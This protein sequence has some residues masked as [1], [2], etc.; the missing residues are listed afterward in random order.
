[1][2]F[3][4]KTIL[5]I[6]LIEGVLLIILIIAGMQ[7]LKSSNVEELHKRTYTTA[8]LFATTVKDAVLATDL[9]SLDNFV[10][11]VMTHPGIVYAR[12]SGRQGAVLAQI[13][14]AALLAR[15][16]KPDTHYD[17]V[18][19]GVFDVYADIVV[20]EDKY[21]R[22][23]IGFSTANID[24]LLSTA[25]NEFIA[26]A[27]TE[28]LL[29]ALFSFVLG[30]YLTKG[31]VSLTQTSQR[32]A[33]GELGG[34]I[35]VSGTDELAQ[36]MR[37]FNEMSHKLKVFYDERKHAED[38][39]HKLNADLERRVRLRTEEINKL[40][41]DLE[42]RVRLRTEE[43]AQANERIEH[44]AL[45]DPLTKLANRTL[46]QDRLHQA[47]L[48]GERE[49]RVFALVMIDLNRFK[50]INDTLGHHNGD[51][52]LRETASRLSEG[53]RQS[54]TIARLGGDEYALLL[55]TVKDSVSAIF[56]LD[57]IV[58]LFEKPMLLD[59]L[60]TYISPSL[61][62]ALYP[63]DG[64]DAETLMRR[65]DVAMYE[66]KHRK[67]GHA[68]YTADLEQDGMDR[69]GLQSEL[70]SGIANAELVLHYQPKIDI[71]SGRV[72]GVEALVRWHH[73]KR[74][75]LAPDDFI[76]L[77]EK[78]GLI[79]PLTTWVLKEALRQCKEWEIQGLDLV[80]SVNISISNLQDPVFPQILSHVLS[81]SGVS[82]A[83]LELEISENGIMVEPP[84]AIEA[85]LCLSQLGVRI[86][87][88]DFGT[89]YSSMAYLSKLSVARIKVDKSFVKDMVD[90]NNNAVI[91]R[92][93]I[94]LGHN[95]GLNVVAE[96]VENNATWDQL[97]LL[98]CDSAQGYC[99]S[100]PIP[101]EQIPQWVKSSSWGASI[102]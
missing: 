39:V 12:V 20:G 7:M 21:G 84:R 101:A 102:K 25:R 10:R 54:D 100:R 76:P 5:G 81:E 98:G 99:M 34:Q 96:G 38:E 47:I 70:L 50:E 40:N 78:T 45:H 18:G 86:I 71:T 9:A 8:Q 93:I 83:K 87:I 59:G 88:D 11:E 24:A 19:D 30:A 52:V 42:R 73:P 22:V 14:D 4:L 90:N 2:S 62:L 74:G 75:L 36:T 13:G 94:N 53:L 1:M 43:L 85:I 68:L 31:L 67:S 77:A 55:P 32:I 69:M 63:K 51:L 66:A 61:G 80:V 82:P 33:T 15:P 79:K 97:K 60:P 23:D 95:L 16:P 65:A 28:M 44:Q 91:V 57:K 89:G 27:L 48:T 72:G 6:A 46:F 29:V 41:A 56:T 37:A 3:R 49:K 26:I 64:T 35:V 17:D 58:Q 92:S